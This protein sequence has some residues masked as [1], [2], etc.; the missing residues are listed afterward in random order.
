[1]SVRTRRITRTRREPIRAR[2]AIAASSAQV[3][4][5]LQ[6]GHRLVFLVD[7]QS[8]PA[9]PGQTS[10]VLSNLE[11][12][13]HSLQA[14]VMDEADNVQ[15]QSDSINF[16][17]SPPSLLQPPSDLTVIPG[18]NNPDYTGDDIPD[19]VPARPTGPRPPAKPKVPGKGSQ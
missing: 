17:L 5:G 9:A 8:F 19:P 18:P 12:G 11:R 4:P 13:S 6:P 14:V 16:H 3:E 1:M 7:G 15:A 2:W 10:M